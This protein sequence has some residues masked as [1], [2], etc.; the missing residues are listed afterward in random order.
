MD[1]ITINR[2][3]LLDEKDGCLLVVLHYHTDKIVS[4]YAANHKKEGKPVTEPVALWVEADEVFDMLDAYE[5]RFQ[6]LKD[7][8]IIDPSGVLVG[9]SIIPF[10]SSI[11]G[12][13]ITP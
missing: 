10:N 1:T 11:L 13:H 3:E 2:V 6:I 12:Y 9:C 7:A 5:D 8:G 4:R